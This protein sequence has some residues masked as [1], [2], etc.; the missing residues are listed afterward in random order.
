MNNKQICYN[1]IS[2]DRG[3]CWICIGMVGCS[4]YKEGSICNN[5]RITPQTENKCLICKGECVPQNITPPSVCFSC[6]TMYN[7]CLI[8]KK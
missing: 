8:C 3:V 1:C 5:C 7:K 4:I 6:D 2:S